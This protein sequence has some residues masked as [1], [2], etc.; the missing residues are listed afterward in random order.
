MPYDRG[1]I[2]A[3][4]AVALA[5][6][7]LARPRSQPRRREGRCRPGRQ[8]RAACGV[9]DAA[10]RRGQHVDVRDRSPRR[11]RADD[12]SRA[13]RRRSRSRSSITVKSVEKQGRRHGR[14]RSR[15]RSR[16]MRTE[17]RRSRMIDEYAYESTITCNDKKFDISP[18][19]F[20]FAGEP[21]GYVGLDIDEARSQGHELG[22]DQGRRRRSRVARRPRRSTGRASRPKARARSLGSGKLELERQFTPQEPEPSSRQAGHVSRPRS[23]A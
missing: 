5:P 6:V 4:L 1:P 18:N 21:G 8:G 16:S 23:S 20:F 2:A 10:A 13:S 19:S 12:R 14:R 3:V 15:R 7:A 17:G 22:A 9:E 11:C